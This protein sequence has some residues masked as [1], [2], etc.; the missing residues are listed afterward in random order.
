MIYFLLK[1]GGYYVTFLRKGSP[2]SALCN[3]GD[4]VALR[5]LLD[6]KLPPRFLATRAVCYLFID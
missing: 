6:R 5:F 4:A 3:R 1:G 2:V